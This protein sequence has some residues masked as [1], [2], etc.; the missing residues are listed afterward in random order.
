MH[1][2]YAVVIKITYARDPIAK[3]R[4]TWSTNTLLY[5][6]HSDVGKVPKKIITEGGVYP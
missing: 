1:L 3:S 5:G 4:D 6:I 2:A